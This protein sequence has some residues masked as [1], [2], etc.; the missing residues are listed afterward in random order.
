MSGQITWC[1]R[2]GCMNHYHG[3][4]GMEVEKAQQMP[5]GWAYVRD[6]GEALRPVKSGERTPTL[7]AVCPAHREST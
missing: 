6:D 4:T 2:C 3:A 1:S 7:L 5:S